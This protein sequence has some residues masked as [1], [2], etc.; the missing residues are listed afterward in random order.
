MT[1]WFEPRHTNNVATPMVN[2]GDGQYALF[3][4]GRQ[5]SE[6]TLLPSV[7][8]NAAREQEFALE[9]AKAIVVNVNITANTALQTI[10]AI[11][12]AQDKTSGLWYSVAELSGLD[13][14][15]AT[16]ERIA[17]GLGIA[18]TLS[19]VNVT[20]SALPLA[21]LMRVRLNPSLGGDYTASVGL[22][23]LY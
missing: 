11:V 15:A 18:N 19:L 22:I 10:E 5:A 4:T 12:E 8:D 21:P 2:L 20:V 9:E 7:Q 6:Q 1:S 3:T 17:I 13:T 23:K 16:I 14:A